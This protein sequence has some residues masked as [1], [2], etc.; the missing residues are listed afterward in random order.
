MMIYLGATKPFDKALKNYIE[1]FNEICLIAIIYHLFLFTD[2]IPDAN[3]QYNAGWSVIMITL[4]NILANM[5]IILVL[6]II[7][8]KPLIAKL[9]PFINKLL[10]RD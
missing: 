7:K 9:K 2:F 5:S 3:Q 10:K 4:F 6:A 1:L 8:I